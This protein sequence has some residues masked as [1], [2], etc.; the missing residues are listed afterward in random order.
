MRFNLLFSIILFSCIT[1]NKH[2][3]KL[4][5]GIKGKV[6]WLEGNFMP[7]PGQ[8]KSGEPVEKELYFFPVLNVNELERSGQF[9]KLDK[10]E[11]SGKTK[12]NSQ[13]KFSI[14]LP[15]GI[16]SLFSKED[17]GFYA[18]IQDGVGK[19]NPIE[20]KENEFTEVVFKID[21]KAAY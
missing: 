14:Q 10:Y 8:N 18:G 5:Q 15:A 4:N 2:L 13:G 9:Y 6:L 17:D 21:Y 1:P 16:Y 7:G 20:V 12:S 11:P 3:A 19:I